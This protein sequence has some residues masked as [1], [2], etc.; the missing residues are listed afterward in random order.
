MKPAPVE[1][2]RAT[3]VEDAL[4]CLEQE[5]EA[6][7]L[8]GGQSL[9]ALMN[10]RL[11]RP[12]VLVDIGELAELDRIFADSD[13]V[14][15]GAL[16]RHRR[17]ELDP[18]VQERLPIVSEAAR[19]IGHVAIRNRGT[20]GGSIAHADPAAEL[21]AVLMSLGATFHVDSRRRGRREVSAEEFFVS[22]FM[23]TLADDELLMWA[24]IPT[25]DP[26]DGWGFVEFARRNGDFAM[27]GAACVVRRGSDDRIRA[28]RA[29][30][31]AVSDKP[32]VVSD[33]TPVGERASA[34]LA[35]SLARAWTPT[36]SGISDYSRHLAH[37][38]LHRAL[39]AAMQ[40]P[41]EGGTG[42]AAPERK[43]AAP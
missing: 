41:P 15:L 16:V 24:R 37:V 39:S 17:L 5:A 20:I 38:A 25:L 7:V 19:H 26:K 11:A 42:V 33:E 21:P 43:E 9:L 6:K 18:L 1:Y 27:C 8:A 12:S 40:P 13:S 4:E 31:L 14:V 10:L 34:E 29:V 3:S 32:L 35:H 22:H 30:L 36:K 2:V 23:T 28:V